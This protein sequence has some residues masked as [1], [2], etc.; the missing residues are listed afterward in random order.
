M[1]F[2][3]AS[4]FGLFAVGNCMKCENSSVPD[5]NSICIRPKYI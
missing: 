4:I 1:K 3:V 5:R 2:L